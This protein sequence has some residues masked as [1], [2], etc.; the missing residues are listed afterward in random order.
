MQDFCKINKSLFLY[1]LKKYLFSAYFVLVT[2]EK[3]YL[4]DQA[5]G[6]QRWLNLDKNKEV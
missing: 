4:T 6:F 1:S 5:K 2:F 3:N